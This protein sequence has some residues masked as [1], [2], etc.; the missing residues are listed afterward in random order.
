M[1]TELNLTRERMIDL[2]NED[3]AA[4]Y[5]AII[6]CVVYSE[7]L[8]RASSTDV[9]RK[10]ELHAADEYQHAARIA[11]Q[12]KDLSGIPCTILEAIKS[13][14]RPITIDHTESNDDPSRMGRHRYAIRHA[15]APVRSEFSQALRAII[16]QEHEH[17][18][19]LAADPGIRVPP[20][21]RLKAKSK[22]PKAQ[23]V[24][25]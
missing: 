17:Q 25:D 19:I 21:P 2:L 13:S 8:K 12:I 22:R 15:G 7:I 16:V 23:P 4:D 20:P 9:A 5:Q 11:R 3:L 24:H 6:A 14:P 1:T 18:S 10:L